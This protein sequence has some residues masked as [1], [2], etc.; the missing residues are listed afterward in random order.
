MGFPRGSGVR[1]TPVNARDAEDTGSVPVLERFPEEEMATHSSIMAWEI[2][3]TEEPGPLQPMGSQ[4][5]QT[6]LSDWACTQ[7]LKKGKPYFISTIWLL[8]N[9]FSFFS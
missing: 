3:R 2:P 4:K 6:W 9:L 7:N 1:N 8:L 5:S